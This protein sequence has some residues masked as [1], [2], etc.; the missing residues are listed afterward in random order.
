MVAFARLDSTILHYAPSDGT[1]TALPL[2][3]DKTDELVEWSTRLAMQHRPGTY[4]VIVR[5]FEDDVSTAEAIAGHASPVT[6]LKARLEV[7]DEVID[8]R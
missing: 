6:E 7:A 8:A 2:V 3:A 1:G 4:D 5:F